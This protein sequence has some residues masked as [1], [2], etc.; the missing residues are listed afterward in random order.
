MYA[1]SPP[2]EPKKNVEE[3]ITEL[4]PSHEILYPSPLPALKCPL[5]FKKTPVPLVNVCDAALAPYT[6]CE[7]FIRNVVLPLKWKSS[8]T[9]LISLS[10]L[11]DI[12]EPVEL[13]TKN[14]PVPSA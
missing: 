10:P 7:L 1:L 5:L 4:V 3:L 8:V 6:S 12:L 9:K 13:P 14:L 11:N 2:F